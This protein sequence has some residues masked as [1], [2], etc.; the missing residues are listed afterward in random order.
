VVK[1]TPTR[2][3]KPAKRAFS[4]M[5]GRDAP[6]EVEKPQ[7]PAEIES[8]PHFQE[9]AHERGPK[10]GAR[11]AVGTE[12][13]YTRGGISTAVQDI[14]GVS[15]GTGKNSGIQVEEHHVCRPDTPDWI[16]DPKQ[17]D[18]FFSKRL[19]AQGGS[20]TWGM[21]HGLDPDKWGLTYGLDRAILV[22]HYLKNYTDELIFDGYKDE[23]QK[24]PRRLGRERW[25]SSAE[26]VRQRRFRLESER[27]AMY[28]PKRWTKASWRGIVAVSPKSTMWETKYVGIASRSRRISAVNLMDYWNYRDGV[29]DTAEVVA[30][31]IFDTGGELVAWMAKYGIDPDDIGDDTLRTNKKK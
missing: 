22:E 19:E 31:D 27:E 1:Q 16:R 24:E 12:H 23:F 2:A 18:E 28:N 20:A 7:Q 9:Q 30:D 6:A 21:T 11:A 25:T 14:T 26:A 13:I 3:R 5:V 17:L 10:F 29:G 8:A 4:G 15:V